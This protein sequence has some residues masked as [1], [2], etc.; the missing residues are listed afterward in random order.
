MEK[1]DNNYIDKAIKDLFGVVGLKGAVDRDKIK[2]LLEG[3]DIKEGIKEIAKHLGLPIE[4][5]LSHVSDSHDPSSKDNFESSSVV[6]TD[7]QKRGAKGITAQV[8]IPSNL[9][10]YSSPELNNF[11]IDVK[12]SENCLDNIDVFITVMAHELSHVL[13]YSIPNENKNNE[14]Y[15]DIT[16]MMLGFSKI[17]LKGRKD[18][19]VTKTEKADFFSS[20]KTIETKTETTSYGYLTDDNFDF[21][22]KKISSMLINY[23]SEK[24]NKIH[25]LL[26]ISE[27]LKSD[28]EKL[29]AF[30][31][32]LQYISR[33]AKIKMSKN[34]ATKVSSFFTQ[35][36]IDDF[37][38]EVNNLE[39]QVNDINSSIEKINHYWENTFEPYRDGVRKIETRSNLLD[40]KRQAIEGDIK[41]LKKFKSLDYRIKIFLKSIKF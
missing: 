40:E 33:K 31:K 27:K 38:Q 19:K 3:G 18:V 2:S 26:E 17:I 8:Y 12:I 6:E 37:E 15:T 36:Y 35:G 13:L 20:Q 1:I 16:A 34:E 25:K 24:F 4:I 28:K 41:F 5:G 32:Y 11:L 14:I 10:M 39:S 23:E 30:K 29:I 21:A 7:E 22:F 9:P